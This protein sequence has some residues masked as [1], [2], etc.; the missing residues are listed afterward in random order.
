[1]IPRVVISYSAAGSTSEA[2]SAAS[3]KVNDSEFTQ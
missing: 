2:V 3:V 1:M